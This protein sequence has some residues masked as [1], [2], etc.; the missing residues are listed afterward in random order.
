[1]V[2]VSTLH[3]I[4][5][6]ARHYFRDELRLA[7]QGA[8]RR[9]R[10]LIDDLSDAQW[11]VPQQ[12]GV[13]P[14]AWE[15]AHCAWF[16][17]FWIQRGPHRRDDQGLVHAARPP[18]AVGPDALL[19]SA[20]LAHAARWTA[21]LPSR[22]EVETMLDATLTAALAALDQ[23]GEDDD[24]LYFHR[25]ALFH[26]DMHN[27]ALAWMRAALG[28][29]APRNSTLP[30]LSPRAAAKMPAEK[31]Q[32]GWPSDAGGFSFDNERPPFEI[33]LAAY[34]I[35]SAPVTAGAFREFVEAGGYRSDE[36]WAS[37]AA[38]RWRAGCGRDH[39]ER[40]RR[41]AGGWE[42]RWFEQWLPLDPGQPVI[43]V[44]A[45]EAEAY[46]AW[47]KRRLPRA[48]E[49]EHAA[50]EGRIDWGGTVWEWTSDPFVPYPG[51]EPGPYADYSAPWFHTHRELRG[52]SFITHARMHH[53]RYR[54]FA[55]PERCDIF[56][57]FRTAV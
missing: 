38:R 21:P 57:G 41:N 2:E 13:N 3:S 14:V 1:M 34:E 15:V 42:T 40:W 10:G 51:F 53:A 4:G 11:R 24:A 22:L 31:V 7:M 45:F 25:L 52:G 36:Y 49:W 32:I 17:E 33:E 46:C 9:M 18:I 37:D 16:W 6:R 19:D 29:P 23:A 27:E 26:D 39:P 35:D 5:R 44:N 55:L 8:R 43:H 20:R 50:V 47:A 48:A 30:V 28:Y 12:A 56:A 54:N